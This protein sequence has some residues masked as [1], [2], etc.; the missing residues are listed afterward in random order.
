MGVMVPSDKIL[1]T[2]REVDAD[3]IGLSGLITPSLDEMVHV[4]NEMQRQGFTMP[5]LIGGAT[6]SKVHTAVKIGRQLRAPG[7]LRPRCLARRRRGGFAAVARRR[8]GLRRPDPRRLCRGPREAPAAATRRPAGHRQGPRQ[9][10][11]HRLAGYQ[12]P[13]PAKPG[14][15]VFEDYDLAELVAYIDWR[16]FF[17]AW[18]L[19]GTLPR[20]PRRSGGGR[21]GARPVQRRPG[22]AAADRR[23]EMADSARRHRALARQSY[24]RRRHRDLH[25]RSRSGVLAVVH[26]AAPADGPQG[27]GP[28][29]FRSGRFRR[30][31]GDRRRRLPRRVRGDRR[32]SASTPSPRISKRTTT[33]TTRS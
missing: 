2:A 22:H 30:A 25:R 19:A 33:T 21:D 8:R 9:R 18:E 15:T 24:R 5:L 11:R 1:D 20:H 14:L 28:V 27:Q 16:P 4:A 29:Q 13:E 12:P 26:Y 17:Q 23:R 7:G 10:R 3:I 6:T 31:E 32:A